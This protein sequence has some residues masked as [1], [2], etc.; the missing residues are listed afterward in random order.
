[1]SGVLYM[2]LHVA[3]HA[4]KISSLNQLA[5]TQPAHYTAKQPVRIGGYADAGGSRVGPV[6]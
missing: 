1:V 4:R 5:I 2:D 6:A 3:M